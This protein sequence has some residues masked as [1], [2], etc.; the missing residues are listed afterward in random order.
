MAIESPFQNIREQYF[1]L[2][3][4]DVT[5]LRRWQSRS[6]YNAHFWWWTM[7]VCSGPKRPYYVI[8]CTVIVCWV[9]AAYFLSNYCSCLA[10]AWLL[11]C[12]IC[13]M[14]VKSTQLSFVGTK[15]ETTQ[16]LR[17]DYYT[18]V[19]DSDN[20][21][22]CHYVRKLSRCA[23]LLNHV[24]IQQRQNNAILWSH[25]YPRW[26]NLGILRKSLWTDHS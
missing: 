19:L 12:N 13:V 2:Y 21:V 14:L 8:L 24:E 22:S 18:Y 6:W 15:W 25:R 10:T 23:V 5:A 7:P 26:M 4:S 20:R 16:C 17:G 9:D 3:Q 11:R 1:S